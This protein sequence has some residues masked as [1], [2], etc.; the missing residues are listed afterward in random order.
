MKI[1]LTCLL[2]AFASSTAAAADE[3]D[4]NVESPASSKR[5]D[6]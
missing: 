2:L 4:A 1:L 3:P 6:S 5:S